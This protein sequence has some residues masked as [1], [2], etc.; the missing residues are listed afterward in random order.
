[1]CGGGC[2]PVYGSSGSGLKRSSK[3][4]RNLGHPKKRLGSLRTQEKAVGEYPK[5]LSCLPRLP[6]NA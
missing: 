6:I 4:S 5:A 2:A 1:G 3:T